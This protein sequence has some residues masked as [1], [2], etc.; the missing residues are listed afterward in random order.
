MKNNFLKV[1]ILYWALIILALLRL[2]YSN[3][4]KNVLGKQYI[5]YFA[6]ICGGLYFV[7]TLIYLVLRKFN[8][9][10]E[11]KFVS[12]DRKEY[13]ESKL[14]YYVIAIIAN[15]V[16]GV[17]T[18]FN[19][20]GL[21]NASIYLLG[22][23]LFALVFVYFYRTSIFI[24]TPDKFVWKKGF[25]KIEC[26][27]TD[28]ISI[29]H[30]IEPALANIVRKFVSTSFF[31]E[32]KSGFTK[33]ADLTNIK[34][35]NNYT[36]FSQG[37]RLIEEIKLRSNAPEQSGKVSMFKQTQKLK[38]VVFLL[39]GIFIVPIVIILLYSFFTGYSLF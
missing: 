27:W 22:I 9:Q 25:K 12:T 18:I 29:N 35:R 7:G 26:S 2:T 39:L 8:N 21:G 34:L 31:I 5:I 14:Q 30:D 17:V 19:V 13:Y 38:D 1:S 33:Y 3:D 36:V 10:E 23:S 16:L 28:V 24:L 15:I 37:E 11:S 4:Y 20:G 32:T 6:L